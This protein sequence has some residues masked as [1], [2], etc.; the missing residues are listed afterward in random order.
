MKNKIIIIFSLLFFQL[1]FSNANLK[2][3]EDYI[4]NINDPTNK[5][6]REIVSLIEIGKFGI[7]E[8][9]KLKLQDDKKK[10]HDFAKGIS[11][12]YFNDFEIATSY[13]Y[14][15]YYA[16]E[17][18]INYDDQ[19]ILC[20]YIFD[21][22]KSL[23]NDSNAIFFLNKIL[24][25]YK[26]T[27]EI[28]YYYF[29][30]IEKGVYFRNNKQYDNAIQHLK[31][32]EQIHE[33]FEKKP[34]FSWLHLHLGRT[35]LEK[36]N[37]EEA[38]KNYD[39]CYNYYIKNNG[40]DLLLY[41]LYEYFLI[42]YRQKKY[43]KA[44][45]SAQEILQLAA[46]N[47]NMNPYMLIILYGN[48]GEIYNIID[49]DKA[50]YYFELALDEGLKLN[51]Y[52]GLHEA[53]LQLL[54]SK[55]VSREIQEKIIT[56]FSIVK[57]DENRKIVNKINSTER[58]AQA[59]NFESSIKEHKKYI[60]Y[61]VILTCFVFLLFTV[62]LIFFTIQ[63]KNIVTINNQ[64]KELQQQ[65]ISLTKFNAE[66]N[67]KYEKI[68]TLNNTLA[69]DIKSGIVSIKELAKK[70][71]NQETEA[72][73]LETT[74]QI[75]DETENLTQTIQFLLEYAKS[76]SLASIHTEIIEW[77]EVIK[78]VKNSLEHLL[79][80]TNPQININSN[81]PEFIG[82]KTHFYQL[83]KN[84]IENSLKYN[85]PAKD[86]FIDILIQKKKEKLII[87]YTDNGIG[88]E[89]ENLEKIFDYF[90]Q[91]KFEHISKGYG[92]G[93]G[94]CKKIVDSYNGKISVSSKVNE[95]TKFTIIM[96]ELNY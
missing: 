85:D 11:S 63:K 12:Y 91:S 95:G 75:V 4:N 52:E 72:L 31:K 42:E 50:T 94:I 46:D 60:T 40:K 23:G 5:N 59:Y 61:Y 64:K 67:L 84:L 16:I 79:M 8:I 14:K 29:Y 9:E 47:P 22:E 43:D 77:D 13:F 41:I 56:Y 86:C 90:N 7:H 62:L 66:I 76:S 30:L 45:E 49:K 1:T 20:H 80:L 3:L 28:D 69:H 82:Y 89:K 10:Y 54:K 68:E 24:Q 73:Q 36:N 18:N 93:L 44:I 25:I 48:M 26:E 92:L 70:I 96:T 27:K 78:Q 37:F 15:I 39:I 38:K 2:K 55:N 74:N 83:F 34:P 87:Q 57:K 65:T 88:I 6:L 17:N 19:F 58:L 53:S 51:Q 71:K 32:A 81:L 35:Y 21:A 33:K